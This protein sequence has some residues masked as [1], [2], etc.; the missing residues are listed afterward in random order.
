MIMAR[1]LSQFNFE[2][3]ELLCKDLLANPCRGML[4]GGLLSAVPQA[5]QA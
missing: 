1:L 4:A 5:S 3:V 2:N